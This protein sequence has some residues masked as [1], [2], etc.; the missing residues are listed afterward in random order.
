MSHGPELVHRWV[1]ELNTLKGQ[2]RVQKIEGSDSWAALS[3]GK[4]EPW[5]F[6]SWDHETFGCCWC[7][8]KEIPSL[9]QL[10]S[11]MPPIIAALKRHLS[12]ATLTKASQINRDRVLDL[13]FQRPVGKDIALDYHLILESADRFSNLILADN[14]GKILEIS[15]H[16][17]PDTNR[18]RTLVPGLPYTPPPPFQG[19]DPEK[20]VA[21]EELPR[22]RGLGRPLLKALARLLKERPKCEESLLTT[23]RRFEVEDPLFCLLPGN[24][25]AASPLSIGT[26]EVIPGTSLQASRYIT[27]EP[28]I[29]AKRD[30]IRV[31][32]SKQ[33]EGERWRLAQ[34]L[35]GFE[36]RFRRRQAADSDRL[37]GQALLAFA[38]LVP[39]GVETVELPRPDG[40]ASLVFVELD[41]QKTASENAQIYFK[42]YRKAI[43]N[44]KG[45]EKEI[46]RLQ[47]KI[48]EIDEELAILEKADL[49]ALLLLKEERSPRLP[50]R[51]KKQQMPSHLSLDHLGC[52]ILVGLTAKGNRHVTFDQASGEDIWFHARNL[53]GA[54]VILKCPSDEIP[55]EVFAVA[56]SLAAH[57][58]RGAGDE[59]VV[60]DYTERKH[61]RHI[62]GS[63]PANVTYR[64]FSSISISPRL[65]RERL[66]DTP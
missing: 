65:W 12:G 13:L 47:F 33:I 16:I 43:E 29:T 53:P 55:E 5:L 59:P 23:L 39:S 40:N 2:L 66:G 4:K 9:L 25:L 56:A 22:L 15:R 8:G 64:D 44:A 45:V 14:E 17:H 35:H 36:E 50:S 20:L 31:S 6:L 38:H 7:R 3:M 57:Y 54:H 32:I 11:F 28:L 46:D 52:R 27:I 34:R 37:K 49:S 58:C 63:G 51:K 10:A 19:I 60:V 61:V 21:P 1:K 42:R 62:P 30:K 26:G 48:D 18:Y 41:P 24:Y